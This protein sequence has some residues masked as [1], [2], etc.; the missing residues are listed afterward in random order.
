MFAACLMY[1]DAPDAFALDSCSLLHCSALMRS[2]MPTLEA[3]ATSLYIIITYTIYV[4]HAMHDTKDDLKGYT[5][6]FPPWSNGTIWRLNNSTRRP[7]PT[8][9]ACGS[10]PCQPNH[11][12]CRSGRKTIRAIWTQG[13]GCSRP[14]SCLNTRRTLYTSLQNEQWKKPWWF[15][16]VIWGMQ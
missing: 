4:I 3:I 2:W 7:C 1:S 8:T 6:F 15:G 14:V 9:S 10:L 11:S 5:I 12:L 16:V 13:I